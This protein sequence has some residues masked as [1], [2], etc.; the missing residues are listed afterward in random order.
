MQAIL[1]I[2]ALSLY[3]T[4]GGGDDND[5]GCGGGNGGEVN[6]DSDGA[7]TTTKTA[8]AAA[9]WMAVDA[10]MI[11]EWTL[12]TTANL[13]PRV[14]KRNDGCKETKT[15]EEETVTDS[16]VIHTPIT[17]IMGRRGGRW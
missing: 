5:D 6:N 11:G 12:V 9:R 14:G 15:E 4:D 2:H 8:R 10:W 1:P 3:Y 13:P 16:V 7:M 17:Q